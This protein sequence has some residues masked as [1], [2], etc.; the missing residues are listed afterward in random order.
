MLNSTSSNGSNQVNYLSNVYAD[1][2]IEET[3]KQSSFT[4]RKSEENQVP[5]LIDSKQKHLQKTLND[6][7][8]D[9]LLLQETKDDAQFRKTLAETLQ[10]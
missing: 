5:R 6:A 4:E 2:V 3:S 8:R 9:Q 1:S 7:R 10:K